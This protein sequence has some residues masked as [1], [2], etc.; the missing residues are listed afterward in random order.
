MEFWN[1]TDTQE[2]LNVLK[3]NW[4]FYALSFWLKRNN[5]SSTGKKTWCSDPSSSNPPL[6]EDEPA[7]PILIRKEFL[8]SKGGKCLPC[9]LRSHRRLPIPVL[10]LP[11]WGRTPPPTP[12]SP[13]QPG[14]GVTPEP[15]VSRG[16]VLRPRHRLQPC[17]GQCSLVATWKISLVAVWAGGAGLN[18]IRKSHPWWWVGS[19]P[20]LVG[21]VSTTTC[22]AIT[23]LATCAPTQFGW[24]LPR[25]RWGQSHSPLGRFQTSGP[26]P[27]RLRLGLTIVLGVKAPAVKEV[28]GHVLGSGFR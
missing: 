24:Q 13:P 7:P 8:F 19:P 9:S 5:P 3:C 21:G 4:N 22:T 10:H 25:P 18:G 6:S 28:W 1:T 23:C 14:F 11:P 20:I 17:A 15:H 26:F 16:A 27:P 12:R 2:A